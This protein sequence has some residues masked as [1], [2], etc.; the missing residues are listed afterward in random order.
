MAKTVIT[1]ALRKEIYQHI[2]GHDKHKTN[3]FLDTLTVKQLLCEIH[4]TYQDWYNKL[5]Y[6]LKNAN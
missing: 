5:V 1:D 3:E 4:P 6:P 2:K